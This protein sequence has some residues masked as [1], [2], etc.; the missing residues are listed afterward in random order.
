MNAVKKRKLSDLFRRG[1]ELTLDDGD[2]GITV[3]IRKLNPVEEETAVRKANARRATY[4][5]QCKDQESEVFLATLGDLMDFDHES[6][7]EYVASDELVRHADALEAE[8]ASAEEWSKDNY[9]QGLY[10]AWEDG[11]KDR[12]F[13]DDDKE[14]EEAQ[15]TWAEIERYN[16]G[17]QEVLEKERQRIKRDFASMDEDELRNDMATRISKMQADL[18]WLVEHHKWEVYLGTRDNADKSKK[19]FE[20]RD[21]IDDLAEETMQTLVAAFRNLNVEG[22]QGKDSPQTATS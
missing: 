14:D 16:E 18:V 13:E 3:Y 11:L 8:Y 22:D 21:E 19:Y 15:R 5:S 10:E 12:Y 4:L 9:L 2:G 1:E 7:L 17:F 20:S 6:L